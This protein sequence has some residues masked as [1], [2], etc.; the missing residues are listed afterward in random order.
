MFFDWSFFSSLLDWVTNRSCMVLCIQSFS[1][2]DLNT[3]LLKQ[4]DGGLQFVTDLDIHVINWLYTAQVT[5]VNSES[6]LSRHQE[7]EIGCMI[8]LEKQIGCTNGL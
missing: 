4:Y 8:Q 6:Q 2:T 1:H 7:Q 3:I 5:D